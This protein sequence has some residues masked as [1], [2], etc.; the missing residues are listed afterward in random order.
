MAGIV[1][2]MS[3]I[4][5]L[6]ETNPELKMLGIYMN[7]TRKRKEVVRI[8][9]EIYR[10]SYPDIYIPLMV[11]DS[12]YVAK[13]RIKASPLCYFVPSEPIT[14]DFREITREIVERLEG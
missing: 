5:S 9:D 11:R 12:A 2:V 14:Q 4:K 6:K 8:M 7:R 10:K 3:K 13:A 1:W